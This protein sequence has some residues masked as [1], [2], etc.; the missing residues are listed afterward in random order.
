MTA[1]L[2]LLERGFQVRMY[3]QDDF[4]GGMLHSYYDPTQD[5]MREHGYHMLPNFY[6]NFWKV[7]EELGLQD[8]FVPR[9]GMQFLGPNDQLGHLPAMYNPSGPQD[10]L[11]NLTGG[12]EAPPDLF[13]FMY[14]MID[15]LAQPDSQDE[16]LDD[17]GVTGFLHGRPYMT[18]QAMRLHSTMWQT[19]WGISSDQS[20]M[21]SYRA[22]LKFSNRYSVPE[23]W[24]IAGNKRDNLIDPWLQKLES[25]EGFELHKRH[26]LERVNVD[27]AAKRVQSLVFRVVEGSPSVHPGEELKSLYTEEV[28][29]SDDAVILA[30]TPGA[31][32][33]LVHDEL[34]RAAPKLGEVQYL[35]ADPLGN[36]QL[37]I[38]KRMSVPKDITEFPGALYSL[39]FLDF[40]QIWRELDGSAETLLN[41]SVSDA[42]SLLSLPPERRNEHHELIIDLDAPSTAIEYVL[43]EVLKRLPVQLHEIDLRRTVYDVLTGEQLFANLAGSWR[44]RPETTTPISNL[45]LAGTYVQNVIDVATIEGAVMT[46]AMA[47]EAVRKSRAPSEEPVTILQPEAFPTEMYQALAVGWAPFVTMAKIW[48][49]TNR[50][51][52]GAGSGWAGLQRQLISTGAQLVQPYL[53]RVPDPPEYLGP[54]NWPGATRNLPPGDPH[55]IGP[56]YWQYNADG[57]RAVGVR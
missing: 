26:L 37:R 53:G 17:V 33:D 22:F 34:Y 2:R 30:V 19:V 27:G 47:A 7:A 55:A 24:F 38:N 6:F 18:E 40:T 16:R 43:I 51:L 36:L 56:V 14:S 10:F 52:G 5:T 23:F 25:F 54:L 20:S 45:W 8:R 49:A 50:M 3:E 29:V 13:I 41:V 12:A 11:R 46:G 48:S 4:V 1:A 31:I 9:E 35:S 39:T 57:T 21:K 28:D 42:E 32:K 15:I 44:H